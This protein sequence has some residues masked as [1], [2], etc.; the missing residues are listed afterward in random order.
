MTTLY[1]MTIQRTLYLTCQLVWRPQDRYITKHFPRPA[2]W[3]LDN[4]HVSS[5]DTSMNMSSAKTTQRRCYLLRMYFLRL[6]C[7][8]LTLIY[9]TSVFNHYNRV[10]ANLA[11]MEDEAAEQSWDSSSEDC[12]SDDPNP[13]KSRRP[14][15]SSARYPGVASV[16]PHP[17]RQAMPSMPLRSRHSIPLFEKS[18]VLVMY[19]S[20]CFTSPSCC[21]GRNGFLCSF[22]VDQLALVCIKS[23]VRVRAGSISR[24]VL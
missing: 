22:A 1:L 17:F 2:Y 5:Y 4:I 7:V 16:Q 14:T 8:Q 18:N 23:Y 3:G 10:R 6:L 19:V 13:G 11:A 24:F 12:T 21:D 9:M 15:G 20:F